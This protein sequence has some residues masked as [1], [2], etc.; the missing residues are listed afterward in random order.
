MFTVVIAEKEHIDNIQEYKV[1]LKPFIDDARV[2][3]CEWRPE[4]NS[5][6]DSVPHLE[7]TVARHSKW[8]A[9]VLCDESGLEKKNPF[10]LV[11]FTPPVFT[12]LSEEEDEDE[13]VAHRRRYL[14]QL[15]KEKFKT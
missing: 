4:E 8:R 5:L 14:E 7:Q 15:Q 10:E 11:E 6:A 2:E 1:F 3:F 12:P 13:V 9:I